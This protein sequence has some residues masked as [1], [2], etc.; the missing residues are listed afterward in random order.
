MSMR[1][2]IVSLGLVIA[3]A[4]CSGSPAPAPSTQP[5]P[6]AT[7]RPAAAIAPPPATLVAGAPPTYERKGR[8]DPFQPIEIVQ[9]VEIKLAVASA[10]LTGI[11]RGSATLALVEMPDGM[12]Y[13]M[14]PG[15]TL[16]EGRL[17]EIGTD[18]VVFSVPSRKGSRTSR[19]FLR[20]PSD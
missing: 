16:A 4:A 11:V 12:G 18:N 6:A 3:V 19:L 9:D 20:L 13:I 7:P 8:R 15:D 5:A 14:Q 1:G 2:A 10:R 17:I